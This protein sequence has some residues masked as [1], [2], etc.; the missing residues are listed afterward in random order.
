MY[1]QKET[2]VEDK[3][4]IA[5]YKTHYIYVYIFSAMPF[6]ILTQYNVNTI[7]KIYLHLQ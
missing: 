6:I 1:S 3:T 7:V 4:M 5:P 2:D